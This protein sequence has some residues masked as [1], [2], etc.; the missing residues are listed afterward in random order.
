MQRSRD[1]PS[2]EMQDKTW[3][4][5]VGHVTTNS[6]P[7][8]MN[9]NKARTIPTQQL[10]LYKPETIKVSSVFICELSENLIWMKRMWQIH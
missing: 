10:G 2:R 7:D 4:E 9:K 8:K 1:D 6:L 5:W 3:S